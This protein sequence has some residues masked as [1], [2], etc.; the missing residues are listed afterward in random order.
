[1]D[2]NLA[3]R[4]CR[5]L[6]VG[7]LL[8]LL[9]ASAARATIQPYALFSTGAVLQRQAKVPVWG[10]TDQADKVTVS[11]AGQEASAIPKDGQWRVELPPLA[12]GGPHVMTISQA[13]ETIEI[14]GVL[15][16]EVWVCAGQSNMQ[17]PVKKSDGADRAIANSAND[18]LR[19]VTLPRRSVEP[20]APEVPAAWAAAGPQTVA[21][22][23]AV[24]YYFGRELQRHLDVPIGLIAAHDG[25]TTAEQWTSAETIDAQA[26]LKNMSKPQGVGTHFNGM[27]APLAPY[28][29]RGV[30]WYQGESNAP[31][32]Y[33]YRTLLPAMIR[34]WRE[35]FGQGDFPFLIVQMPP[36]EAIVRE[37]SD[38]VWAELR[39]AQRHVVQST[40]NTALVITTDLGDQRDIHPRAKE[41]VGA[42]AA[43]A[44]R[45]LAYD[46]RLVYCGPLYDSMAV[47][48]D[49][50]TLYFKHVGA[51][52]MA[53]NA[54]LVGFTIAGE[55]QRFHLATATIV[56]DTVVVSSPYVPKPIAAR[57][58]WAAYPVG[59]LYNCDGLPASPFRTDS[60]PITTQERK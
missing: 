17:W 29:I 14:A 32:A 13:N 40:G 59:N 38:S 44:A 37:P 8:C 50:V 46:E 19:L 3:R 45:G 23:S 57:Y 47:D 6:L 2:P 7:A 34:N 11:L 53:G 55:D 48:G 10:T 31:R 33:Q 18:K 49:R 20:A 9:R 35:T 36:Y 58:S 24:A 54:P 51:G 4:L 52:L 28:A 21:D 25:G 43:L 27:I 56:G 16:G 15:V 42:R 30:L 22:Y 12:A 1:M 5:A 60:F 26:D 41:P 39:D